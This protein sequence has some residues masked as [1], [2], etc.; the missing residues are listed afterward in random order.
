VSRTTS[1]AQ[2][3]TAAIL[4][5]ARPADLP[6]VIDLLSGAGLPTAG[7]PV[8]LAGFIVAESAGGLVGTAGLER[9]G[10]AALLRSVVVAPDARGTGLG[11]A[12]V[13]R[14]IADSAAQGVGDLYLLTTTAETYFPRHGFSRIAR[15]AVPEPV[16][17]SVEFQ[18]ACPASAAVMHRRLIPPDP[19][20]A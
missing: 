8:G 1:P 11:A 20:P 18:G 7:V 5:Q 12:L 15:E 19:Q 10:T 9:Y 3:P 13:E 16:Q 2:P 17:A 4:R 14:I 6:A